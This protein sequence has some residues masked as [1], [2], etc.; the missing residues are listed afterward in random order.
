MEEWRAIPGYG[1]HYE[2]SSLGRIRSRSR[3]VEKKHSSGKIMVQQYPGRILNTKPGKDGYI[4]IHISVSGVKSNERVHRLILMAFQRMPTYGEFGLHKDGDPSNN[5]P[6][7]LY[8]GDHDQNMEDRKRHG[9]YPIGSDHPMAV[10]TPEI[11][12]AVRS[13]TETGKSLAAQFGIGQST[14]SRI[15]R[16]QSWDHI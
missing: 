13:S 6:N 12:M 5:K 3:A 9:N 11:V 2:A 10:V 8:W 16:R 15:R 7:N 4:I 14:I 1:N